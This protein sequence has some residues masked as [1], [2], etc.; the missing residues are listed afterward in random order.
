MSTL[1]HTDADKKLLKEFTDEILPR[2]PI[3]KTFGTTQPMN[4]STHPE[5]TKQL[6][7]D[8]VG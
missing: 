2:T 6:G 5:I 3:M 8:V 7:R 4:F 1:K